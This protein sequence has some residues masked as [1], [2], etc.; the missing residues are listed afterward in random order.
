MCQKTT[1]AGVQELSQPEQ[2]VA[3]DSKETQQELPAS[4]PVFGD[5]VVEV[6]LDR[7]LKRR[8]EPQK[9]E[10]SILESLL[11]YYTCY[12]CVLYYSHN[13]QILL[14]KVRK[15][16]RAYTRASVVMVIAFV[17][18]HTPRFIPNIVEIVKGLDF[19]PV[20]EEI[21]WGCTQIILRFVLSIL[22]SYLL[23]TSAIECIFSD[24]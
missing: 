8:W 18:S 9:I 2:S 24:K 20:S 3:W 13:Y 11:Q 17:V 19:P 23:S 10:N 16:D 14:Y 22:N 15:R 6:W 21:N 1:K 5:T 7:T 4:L 12:N